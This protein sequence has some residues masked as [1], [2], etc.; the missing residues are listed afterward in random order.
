MPILSNKISH[1]NCHISAEHTMK[2]LICKLSTVLLSFIDT[3]THM[4]VYGWYA[5]T[6]TQKKNEEWTP[7]Q[8]TRSKICIV[9]LKNYTEETIFQMILRLFLFLFLSVFMLFRAMPFP[10]SGVTRFSTS[11][12]Q[13]SLFD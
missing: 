11:K 1:K 3:H 5:T 13:F 12:T 10:D 4:L 7:K 2:H 8:S 9:I 6:A